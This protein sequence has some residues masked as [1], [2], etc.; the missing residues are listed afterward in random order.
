MVTFGAREWVERSLAALVEHTDVDFEL[1]V[2]DN[3]STDGTLD[4]LRALE[5]ATV[6]EAGRN[7]GFGVANNL[8]ALHARGE[9][10][11]LL[12]SD[13]IVPAR[14]T[15]L[16]DTFA[17]PSVGAVVP[18]YVAPDGR[19]Q[20]A[21]AAVHDDALV[22]PFGVGDVP[23]W[24]FPR[25]VQ[26][27]SAACLVIPR[28]LFTE[29]G[30]FD[31]A[32]SPAYFEDTDLA[33]RIWSSGRRV[34]LDPSVRV[35]HAQGA[36]SR[37]LDEAV[38]RRER[39]RG[40]FRDRWGAT[41]AGRPRLHAAPYPHHFVAARDYHAPDRLLL[42]AD[43]GSDAATAAVVAGALAQ[44]LGDGRVT[45]AH[46]VDDTSRP[47]ATARHPVDEVER[48][49]LTRAEIDG[50]LESR[51]GHYSTLVAAPPLRRA[52][53]GAWFATQGHRD[54]ADLD[55]L[56]AAARDGV[57]E[58]LLLDHGFVPRRARVAALAAAGDAYPPF[59]EATR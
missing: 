4:V 30:G 22:V 19:V 37:S 18:V 31:A 46:L 21:G 49:D 58:P 50:W 16:S 1:V 20:E 44:H 9:L 29:L 47:D 33:F 52:L 38:A 6:L 11:C 27:G 13:A 53:A 59:V 32:F 23:A 51:A 56:A 39:N 45:L 55:A 48:V 34:V 8:A 10:L 17:D 7:L 25:D 43:A 35:E 40:K 28:R 57:L 15:R 3:G 5:G 54:T 14:W 24:E 26:Y 42:V 41:L 2:V 12:N 36:S